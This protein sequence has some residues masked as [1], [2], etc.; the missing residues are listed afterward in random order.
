LA[1]LVGMLTGLTALSRPFSDEI[2]ARTQPNLYDLAI[3]LFSGAA[4]AYALSFS[5]AAGALPG[6]AIAAA[7]V[8]PLATV[9][10]TLV[11]GL[12]ALISGQTADGW[13][14]L[15]DSLG[16]LLLFTTNLIAISTAASFVFFV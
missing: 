11:A 4:A 13:E 3:A 15:E 8:P 7:L 14:Y 12:A 2:L 1:I 10:I 16:A 5:Q 6:V 9:G